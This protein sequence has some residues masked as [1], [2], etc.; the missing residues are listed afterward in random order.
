MFGSAQGSCPRRGE[1][2][3]E[4]QPCPLGCV[5]SPPGLSAASQ[6]RNQPRDPQ[7]AMGEVTGFL[8]LSLV[9]FNLPFSPR[10]LPLGAFSPS[11]PCTPPAP[12]ASPVPLGPGRAAPSP[13]PGKGKTVLR[14]SGAG[15]P[16]ALGSPHGT[17]V[18]AA[19]SSPRRA[20]VGRPWG[21]RSEISD[22]VIRECLIF[23]LALRG[24][25]PGFNP[26]QGSNPPP[27]S[28]LRGQCSVDESPG[29]HLPVAAGLWMEMGVNKRGRN[30]R[31]LRVFVLGEGASKDRSHPEQLHPRAVGSELWGVL[32]G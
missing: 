26:G 14:G 15:A 4:R 11:A 2:G 17:T 8:P 30:Q 31:G 22:C 20:G 3:Q 1:R 18:P 10:C 27:L 28:C 6:P 7:P 23:L 32:Q 25:S 9:L 29:C 13:H 16:P 24:F 5:G 21:C 19:A 12:S